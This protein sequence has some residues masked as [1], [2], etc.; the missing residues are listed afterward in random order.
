MNTEHL[1]R[2]YCVS[3]V[4]TWPELEDG[5]TP[6]PGS[7]MTCFQVFIMKKAK[8]AAR[9][10]KHEIIPPEAAIPMRMRCR[11]WIF[12]MGMSRYQAGLPL[13]SF[14]VVKACISSVSSSNLVR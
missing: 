11:F 1:V 2:S 14:I 7:G 3:V 12:G 13:L 9:C 4:V 6:I 10:P 8:F 5:S